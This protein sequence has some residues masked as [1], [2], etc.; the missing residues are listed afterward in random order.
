MQTTTP[1]RRYTTHNIPYWTG[2][3]YANRYN[4]ST[5][6]CRFYYCREV[7]KLIGQNTVSHD[8]CVKDVK[9]RDNNY[10]FLYICS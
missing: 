7:L 2:G 4:A 1:Q 5:F 8:S 3:K 10:V 9:Y 6:T